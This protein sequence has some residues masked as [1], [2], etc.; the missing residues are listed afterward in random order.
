MCRS[1]SKEG[2]LQKIILETLVT[3]IV[4]IVLQPDGS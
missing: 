4:S 1:S 3:E 2:D